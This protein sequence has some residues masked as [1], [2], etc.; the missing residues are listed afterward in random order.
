MPNNA[1][2]SVRKMIVCAKLNKLTEITLGQEDQLET[3]FYTSCYV[4]LIIMIQYKSKPGNF[5]AV[6]A[7]S[8][9]IQYDSS[10]DKGNI[11]TLQN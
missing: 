9:R 8:E 2:S 1:F 4:S 3:Y 5:C 11:I 7:I 10:F 6:L